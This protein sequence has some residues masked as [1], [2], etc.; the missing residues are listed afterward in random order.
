[1]KKIIPIIF[2]LLGLGGG[3]AAG[4]F[5][6]PVPDE[7][8]ADAE[9]PTKADPETLPEYV[10]MSNQFIVPIVEDARVAA[11]VIL[12]ISVEVVAGSTE[13]VYSREPK[14]RD[15][16]LQVMFDHA[17]AGGFKGSFTDGSNLILLRDAL[18]EAATGILGHIVTDVLIADI[19]RQDS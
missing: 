14:L 16:F 5:L 12:S 15:A 7:I 1:M 2:A 18:Q 17:N 19:V 13:R 8:A 9:A 3:T 4:M 10:K 6:R 11:M